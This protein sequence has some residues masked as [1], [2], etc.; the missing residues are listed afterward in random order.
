[1]FDIMSKEEKRRIIVNY[2]DQKTKNRRVNTIMNVTKKT[3]EFNAE[4]GYTKSHVQRP[5]QVAQITKTKN[6]SNKMCHI[7]DKSND[8]CRFSVTC[9][10]CM[11]EAHYKCAHGKKYK[12]TNCAMPNETDCTQCGNVEEDYFVTCV[13]CK[14]VA[15][16]KCVHDG[17]QYICT[18]CVKQQEINSSNSASDSDAESESSQDLSHLF[19]GHNSDSDTDGLRPN[20]ASDSDAESVSSQDLNHL[21]LDTTQT[22]MVSISPQPLT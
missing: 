3:W 22:L 21:F 18:N 16:Y 5:S 6:P 2:L 15:H 10:V 7:C 14:N 20:P 11:K 9:K 1:M 13:V 8:D 4:K 19:L 12:C 17:K